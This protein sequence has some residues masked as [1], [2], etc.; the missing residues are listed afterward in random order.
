MLIPTYLCHGAYLR[1]HRKLRDKYEC[2]V[3]TSW[4]ISLHRGMATSVSSH[5]QVAHVLYNGAS[6]DCHALH[7]I[8]AASM[9]T[10]DVNV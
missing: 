7:S 10:E 5:D 8:W 1:C 6:S 2:V 9:G 4:P 3:T